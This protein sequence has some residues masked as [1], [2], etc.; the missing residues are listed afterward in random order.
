MTAALVESDIPGL[1]IFR[2]GKVRDVYDAGDKLLII[3]TDRVSAFD[4]VLPTP[5]P[6][7]G[8]HLTRISR[9]WFER[10]KNIV[11]NHMISTDLGEIERLLG[12]NV[13]LDP[14]SLEGRTMLC[15]KAARIDAECV[16]RGYLAGS[17]WKE[18]RR[19]GTVCG[20]RL[21]AGLPEAARLPAPVFT[22]AAKADEGHDEN[23]SFD[24]LAELA[25]P[26][27]AARLKALSLALYK[28]A[29]RFLES[30]GLI[31]AD[32][33]FEFGL[34]GDDLVLIDEA[35]TPDSSRFWEAGLWKPG[36]APPSFDKQFV[37]DY[38]EVSLGW[39]KRPPAPE[40][41]AE[42]VRGTADRYREALR[43]ITR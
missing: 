1:K 13:R 15:R 14:A 10:T 26:A 11:P 9:F 35:L 8:K 36:S 42:V 22:P 34:L 39:D 37:R 17:G 28:E 3:S 33:K 18:Y 7:K 40:L 6:D 38:L 12:G 27:R 25:G 29:A 19:T 30:R 23:I 24:R 20:I 16:V 31:L 43:R 21:P 32:T 4:F 5:I 41:P 2:R